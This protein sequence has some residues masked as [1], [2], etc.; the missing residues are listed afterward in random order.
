[1]SYPKN[2]NE[3]WGFVDNY[4]NDLESI[5][6]N[7]YPNQKDFPDNGWPENNTPQAACN[8]IIKQLR[9]ESRIWKNKESFKAYI[10]HLKQTQD[11]KLDNIFQSSWF[12][13]PE[14]QS[15]RNL[16]AFHVFCDLCS[17]SHVLY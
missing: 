8:Q 4:W 1:M 14:T 13:M 7:Y 2:K 11:D 9:K 17:E 6:L 12:G 10:N 3:W 15:S 5:V 16:S